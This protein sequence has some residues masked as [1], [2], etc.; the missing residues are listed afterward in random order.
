MDDTV[1]GQAGSPKKTKAMAG[2]REFRDNIWYVW[3]ILQY[4]EEG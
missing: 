2:I 3:L 4:S 1:A